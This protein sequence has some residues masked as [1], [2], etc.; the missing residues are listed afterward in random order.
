MKTICWILIISMFLCSSCSST[1]FVG[2]EQFS[3]DEANNKLEGKKGTITLTYGQKTNGEIISV[4]SDSTS[5]FEEKEEIIIISKRVGGVI[6]M[7]EREKYN[8]FPDIEG[9]Q[10]RSEA[11]F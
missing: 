7:E 2:R 3:Y 11:R 1:H 4:T 8:L 9:F 6:D 10:F 5:W